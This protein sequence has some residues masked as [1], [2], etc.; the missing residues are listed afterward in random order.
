MKNG[1]EINV[2]FPLCL[3]YILKMIYTQPQKS[4]TN[5]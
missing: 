4:Q 2:K 5:E 3:I 1:K